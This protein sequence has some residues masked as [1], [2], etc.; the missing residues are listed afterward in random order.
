MKASLAQANVEILS[1]VKAEKGLDKG[2]RALIKSHRSY[3]SGKDKTARFVDDVILDLDSMR[4]TG[5]EARFDYD[6]SRDL[7]KSVF[8]S[9]GA[10]VSDSEK[11]ATAQN[12]NV[13]FDAN[14]FTF[15]RQSA[16]RCRTMMSYAVRKSCFLEGGKQGAGPPRPR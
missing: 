14:K 4:I 1:E 16:C 5:T 10:R 8:V 12:V 15:P 9:G 3:F 13:D 7:V 6:S 2:R 11:W